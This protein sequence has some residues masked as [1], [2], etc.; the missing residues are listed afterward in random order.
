MQNLQNTRKNSIIIFILILASG[1]LYSCSNSNESNTNQSNTKPI[2]RTSKWTQKELDN[3][4]YSYKGTEFEKYQVFQYAQKIQFDKTPKQLNELI[5]NGT[6]KNILSDSVF[7]DSRTFEY[8]I[9]KLAGKNPKE[10]EKIFGKPNSEEKVNPSKTPCP[11]SK[12]YYLGDLIEIVYMR[13][14]ADWI[15]INLPKFYKNIKSENF[16]ISRFDDYAY[17]K[18]FTE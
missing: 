12:K 11:C 1:F 4:Y 15:T 2:A 3:A 6:I 5:D 18:A 14:K 9:D 8:D 13:N 7:S 16:G 10:I 17:I